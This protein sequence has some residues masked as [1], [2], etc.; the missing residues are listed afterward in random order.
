MAEQP[1]HLRTSGAAGVFLMCTL[2]LL[3]ALY[4]ALFSARDLG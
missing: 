3:V 2:M 1:L 4:V